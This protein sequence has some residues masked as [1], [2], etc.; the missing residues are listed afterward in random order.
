MP[1]SAHPASDAVTAT[2]VAADLVI[3]RGTV[4]AVTD[5]RVVLIDSDPQLTQATDRD[6]RA[7]KKQGQQF[8]FRIVH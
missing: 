7:A 6:G 2:I 8:C 1:S 3:F 5:G 4:M